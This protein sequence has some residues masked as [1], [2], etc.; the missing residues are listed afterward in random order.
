MNKSERKHHHDI[1]YMKIFL[2]SI[3]TKTYLGSISTK[4]SLGF[5]LR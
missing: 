5:K 1:D 2:T 3:P 4:I